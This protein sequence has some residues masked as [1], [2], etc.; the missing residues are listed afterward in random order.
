ML[1]FTVETLV[2]YYFKLLTP[3]QETTVEEHLVDCASC[4]REAARL[5]GL[6]SVWDRW[7]ALRHAE[8]FPEEELLST[9]AP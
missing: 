9:A 6:I 7:T 2:D 4:S 1:H 5:Y 8:A 3:A